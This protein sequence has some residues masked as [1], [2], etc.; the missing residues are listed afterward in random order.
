MVP[1]FIDAVWNSG[2]GITGGFL[3]KALATV[4]LILGLLKFAKDAPQLF[5]TIFASGGGLF[6]GLDW[7][8]GMKRRVSEN[9][10]AMKGIGGAVGLAA[11]GVGAGVMAFR[12][13]YKDANPKGDVGTGKALALGLASGLRGFGHGAFAGAKN[14]LKNSP[15]EF[16]GKALLNAAS[17]GVSSGQAS[18]VKAS[19]KRDQ[20]G[21]LMHPLQSIDRHMTE[22]GENF[23]EGWHNVGNTLSGANINNAAVE[24]IKTAN[25]TIDSYLG[26]AESAVKPYDD[27][28]ND[29]QKK[30]IK[31]ESVD[32]N[33]VTYTLKGD[34]QALNKYTAAGGRKDRDG[35]YYNLETGK[36]DPNYD[37]EK[38][39]KYSNSLSALKATFDRTKN[40]KI[41]SK[42]SKDF[43]D[44]AAT[45]M[46]NL[47]KQLSKEIGNLGT[48]Q[49]KALN[50]IVKNANLTH[51]TKNVENI[52]QFLAK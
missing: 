5:K 21:G 11:G 27:A 42:V 15:T 31:G 22:F 18:E 17:S 26:L 1:M 3:T 10:Y 13:G 38:D 34:G 37:P 7:K 12:K 47:N 29:L 2:D 14:G 51:G 6:A 30:L 41:A 35:N 52:G 32:Y 50:T 36:F 44:G 9:E 46:A 48:D 40:E 45:Y 16:S 24:T 25:G 23:V 33:G 43:K 4:C 8:P 49:L 28:F 19:N 20:Y 39:S